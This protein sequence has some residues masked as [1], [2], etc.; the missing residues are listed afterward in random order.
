MVNKIIIICTCIVSIVLIYFWLI[1]KYYLKV[2]G[3]GQ[4]NSPPSKLKWWEIAPEHNKYLE[5][6]TSEIKPNPMYKYPNMVNKILNKTGSGPL[7]TLVTDASNNV[8][9]QDDITNYVSDFTKI[10]DESVIQ[11][12]DT[13]EAYNL[14]NDFSDPNNADPVYAGD[15]VQYNLYANPDENNYEVITSKQLYDKSEYPMLY[16]EAF[17]SKDVTLNVDD[18]QNVVPVTRDSINNTDNIDP[19]YT[20]GYVY[21]QQNDDV[22]Q[23]NL[24]SLIQS[25]IND[26]IASTQSVYL[27]NNV[28]DDSVFNIT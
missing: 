1:K 25:S 15:N 11:Q 9:T 22:N 6:L 4:D 26:R 13:A 21:Y 10:R 14:S 5:R 17:Q 27:D 8:I 19:A 16:D 28:L 18:N 12:V 7:D 2:T 3:Y 24:Y 23:Q 20:D